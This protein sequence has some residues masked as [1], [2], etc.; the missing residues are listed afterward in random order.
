MQVQHMVSERKTLVQCVHCISNVVQ[1]MLKYV[2]GN[3]VPFQRTEHVAASSLAYF[4][5][6]KKMFTNGLILL[7]SVPFKD[8]LTPCVLAM[9]TQVILLSGNFV[10]KSIYNFVIKYDNYLLNLS[11][12][13]TANF[14]LWKFFPKNC[15]KEVKKYIFVKDLFIKFKQ[16]NFN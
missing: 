1:N 2:I 11:P 7:A 13:T 9:E 15:R 8:L 10:K 16:L 3:I 12:G 4:L 14:C 5:L 6:L